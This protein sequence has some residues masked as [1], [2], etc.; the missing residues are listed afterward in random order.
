V[1]LL[2]VNCVIGNWA[3]ATARLITF[4]K[5]VEYELVPLKVVLL[6]DII[7]SRAGIGM[8]VRSGPKL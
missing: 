4:A 5:S 7:N 2:L 6:V 8:I 1:V 3:M